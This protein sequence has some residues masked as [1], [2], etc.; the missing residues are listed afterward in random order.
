M[1]AGD[2]I[3]MSVKVGDTVLLPVS[4]RA[5]VALLPL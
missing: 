5:S 1:Q 4:K 2:L 3:P